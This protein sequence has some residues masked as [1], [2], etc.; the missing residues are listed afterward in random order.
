MTRTKKSN[1]EEALKE[2]NEELA[3]IEKLDEVR[4]E[5]VRE[6]E[7]KAL[8]DDLCDIVRCI[9]KLQDKYNVRTMNGNIIAWVLLRRTMYT[10]FEH[11]PMPK[12][13]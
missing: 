9:S 12:W 4:D 10:K 5:I 11:A 6:A 3:R 13:D 7:I 1:E 8:T 2:V